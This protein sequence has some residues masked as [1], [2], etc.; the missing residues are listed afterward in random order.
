MAEDANAK[1]VTIVGASKT[2]YDAVQLMASRGKQVN[3]VIRESGGGGVWMSPP[4]VKMGPFTLMLE[5]VATMRFFT[6]FSPCIWGDFDGFGWIRGFLHGTRVGRWLTHKFW[7]KLRMD[8][9]NGNGY[10]RE[11]K[12]KHLEPDEGWVLP[13][14]Q[15]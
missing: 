11:E 14:L 15:Q 3:W 10:R 4:W 12:L 5:H 13:F 1:S 8:G 7:E 9:V 6:W 2:G